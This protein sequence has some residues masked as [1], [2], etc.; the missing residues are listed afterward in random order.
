MTAEI[1]KFGSLVNWLVIL[2]VLLFSCSSSKQEYVTKIDYYPQKKEEVSQEKYRKAVYILEQTYAAIKHDSL[3]INYADHLNIAYAY[4]LLLEPRESIFSE[5]KLAQEKDLQ[6]TAAVFVLGVKS[7]DHFRLTQ[8]EYDSLEKM[9][10]MIYKQNEDENEQFD[11]IEY[12][13]KGNYDKEL[14]ELF[15]S[16]EGRDQKHRKGDKKMELQHRLDL[17]NIHEIDSLYHRYQQYIGKTL[18]GEKFEH[19][20]WLVIQ[21][22]DLEH[23]EKYLPVIYQAVKE[24]EL[25]ETPLK[26]LIDRIHSKKYGSQIFGSQMNIP[27]ASKDTIQNISASYKI[28]ID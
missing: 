24:N 15:V 3:H 27:L 22:A 5:L 26:M 8:V 6:S 2:L 13:D 14:I 18:V 19:V 12:S 7:P 25:K 23:Q 17:E 1:D 20:M 28:A 16:I 21:H 11:I 4:S 9:F 10:T